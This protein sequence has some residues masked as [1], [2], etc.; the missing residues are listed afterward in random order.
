MSGVFGENHE[1]SERMAG[2]YQSI[3]CIDNGQDYMGPQ[4]LVSKPEPPR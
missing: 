2:E 3:W 1:L 4:V